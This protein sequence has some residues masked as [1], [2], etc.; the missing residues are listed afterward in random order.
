MASTVRRSRAR[1]EQ[2]KK[3]DAVPFDPSKFAGGRLMEGPKM[4]YCIEQRWVTAL[5]IHDEI[6][7][8]YLWL[9]ELR[10]QLKNSRCAAK[11]KQKL[12]EGI[13]YL[14]S[15]CESLEEHLRGEFSRKATVRRRLQAFPKEAAP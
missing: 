14:E 2:I 3:D 10:S 15:H 9:D 7:A 4:T 13:T 12:T 1:R 5:P 8:I 11:Q 6:Q